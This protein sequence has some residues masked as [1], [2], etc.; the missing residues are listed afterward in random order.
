M[1]MTD[2]P[3]AAPP[4]VPTSLEEALD[5]YILDFLH[6]ELPSNPEEDLPIDIWYRRC[7]L[8]IGHGFAPTVVRLP[9]S[10]KS[11]IGSIALPRSG[12]LSGRIACSSPRAVST[13]LDRVVE[14]GWLPDSIRFISPGSG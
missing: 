14:L 12:P 2:S 11:A 6:R 1:P 7:Y 9:T 8:G 10:T 4:I 13:D 5:T 3:M